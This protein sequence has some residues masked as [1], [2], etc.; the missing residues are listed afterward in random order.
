MLG[1]P[2]ARAGWATASALLVTLAVRP[3]ARAAEPDATTPPTSVAPTA[4]AAPELALTW[5]APP[6]CPTAADVQ[7]QFGRLLGGDAHAPSGKHITATITVRTPAPARWSLDLATVLDGAAGRRN[8]EGDSCASVASAAS[9]ILAL[10]IDPAAAARAAAESA[11]PPKPPAPPPP[12]VKAPPRQAR[13]TDAVPRARDIIGFARVFAGG[14]AE[15]LPTPAPAVGIALG[16]RRRRLAA[17]LSVLATAEQRADA[18]MSSTAGGD[19]RLIV[20]GARACGALGGHAVVWS[21]CAG[22]ELERL[23]GTGFGT[24]IMPINKS[25]LM[26]AGT[27]GLLVSVPVTA[28]VAIALDLDAVARVYRPKMTIDMTS[29]VLEVPWFSA[30]ASL[31]VV[32]SL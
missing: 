16:A 21:V 1:R 20:G 31:G 8:L 22:G 24:D 9:L 3:F 10:M 11:P 18:E 25:I 4:P 15:L 32:I 30:F 6:G 2:P 19:L 26:G 29:R 7:T 28:T 13:D 17:E 12:T 5:Q 23:S 14:V 27:A